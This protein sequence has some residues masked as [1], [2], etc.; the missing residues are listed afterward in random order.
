MAAGEE[1]YEEIY[2]FLQY[3][4]Y[5]SDLDK[6]HKRNFRRK[7]K[8]NYKVERGLLFYHHK[9]SSEWKQV[10][11]NSKDKERIL[12][13]CHTSCAEG[14]E[15][16]VSGGCSFLCPKRMQFELDA[17]LLG[18]GQEPRLRCLYSA[19]RGV[20]HGMVPRLIFF[21]YQ[22]IFHVLGGGGGGV[23]LP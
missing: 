6:N 11:R 4:Q 16:A 14:K 21:A 22:C 20:G 10:P 15:H 3:G 12:A 18:L 2:Q 8:N 1:D 5:P 9:N 13:S 7:A 23:I 19:R 17:C